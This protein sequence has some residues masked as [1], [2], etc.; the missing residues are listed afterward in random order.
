MDQGACQRATPEVDAHA[1][2]EKPTGVQADSG[3]CCDGSGAEVVL[4]SP[5]VPE[6]A[7]PM[8]HGSP[9]EVAQAGERSTPVRIVRL[10]PPPLL[11]RNT[12]L[13]I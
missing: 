3:A 2:C 5:E 13:L 4:A 9:V 12:V 8:L 7:P 10:F 1:C 6:V 11:G